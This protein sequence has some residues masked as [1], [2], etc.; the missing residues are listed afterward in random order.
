MANAPVN[1]S[2]LSTRVSLCSE[3]E[4]LSGSIAIVGDRASDVR[5]TTAKNTVHSISYL[6]GV[7]Y[8]RVEMVFKI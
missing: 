4:S 1:P 3:Q 6:C 2:V 5:C 7:Y 8:A